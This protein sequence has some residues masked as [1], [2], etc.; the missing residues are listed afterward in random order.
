MYLNTL[1][2][3]KASCL[4]LYSASSSEINLR[5]QVIVWLSFLLPCMLLCLL[6]FLSNQIAASLI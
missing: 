1:T 6:V 2:S 5:A 4:S 3:K